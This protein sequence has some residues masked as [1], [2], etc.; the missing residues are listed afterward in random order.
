MLVPFVSSLVAKPEIKR[1]VSVVVVF[2]FLLLDKA[3]V[4]DPEGETSSNKGNTVELSALISNGAY[5]QYLPNT[6]DN[7][8]SHRGGRGRL[9]AQLR[10]ISLRTLLHLAVLLGSRHDSSDISLCWDN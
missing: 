10:V 2:E 4:K 1:C 8:Q 5:L 3:S 6:K 9:L 7:R